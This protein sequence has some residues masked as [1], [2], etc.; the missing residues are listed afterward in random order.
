MELRQS[1]IDAVHVQ[2]GRPTGLWGRAAALLMAHRSS[3]RR[4]NSSAVSLLDVVCAVGV[5]GAGT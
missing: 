3:S 2:F 4:R 1:A 5:N